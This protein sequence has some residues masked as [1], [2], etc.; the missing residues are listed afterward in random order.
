[1]QINRIIRLVLSNCAKFLTT[2]ENSSYNLRVDSFSTLRFLFLRIDCCDWADFLSF[3][4]FYP[5]LCST[6]RRRLF[7]LA[8]VHPNVTVRSESLLFS[9]V[10]FAGRNRSYLFPCF[11]S[12]SLILEHPVASSSVD[13][14]S[15]L[16]FVLRISVAQG[17]LA[18]FL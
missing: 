3:L 7:Y 12:A 4:I 15:I 8:L 6:N 11:I 9:S 2:S 13:V 5:Q 10:C 1:M 14:L 16:S 17:S 18:L